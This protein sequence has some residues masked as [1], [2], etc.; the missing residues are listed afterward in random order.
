MPVTLTRSIELDAQLL[1]VAALSEGARRQQLGVLADQAQEHRQYADALAFYDDAQIK[2]EPVVIGCLVDFCVP[3]VDGRQVIGEAWMNVDLPALAAQF[4]QMLLNETEPGFFTG[5][6]EHFRR[7]FRQR[8][9]LAQCRAKAELLQLLAQCLFGLGV[10]GDQLQLVT[11][12]MAD[13]LAV[14]FAMDAGI[15]VDERQ[16]GAVLMLADHA[17]VA[18]LVIDCQVAAEAEQRDWAQVVDQS[19]LAGNQRRGQGSAPHCKCE[20]R[21]TSLGLGSA[22]ELAHNRFSSISSPRLS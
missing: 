10:A 7:V 1:L 5:Q 4:G 8:L 22:R 18:G 19:F 6:L 16:P 2:I 13:A 17:L 11:G 20:M 3:A 9:T 21:Q 15:T 14:A 12:Q